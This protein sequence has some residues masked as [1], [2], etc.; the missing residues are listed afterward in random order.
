ME[1]LIRIVS[2]SGIDPAFLQIEV[3]ESTVME[4]VDEAVKTLQRIKVLGMKVA[5][6][7][8]G[9]GYSSL[10]HLSTLP[11]DRLK[12]D[13]SFIR[14]IGHDRTSRAITKAIIVLGHTLKLEVV[15]EGIESEDVLDYLRKQGCDQA[16]G[17]LFSRPLSADEFS[18]WY[19]MR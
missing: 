2:D 9:T 14:R 7:D 18:K 19:R 15:G 13:Q 17:F 3:T 12:V 11:L 5:L 8:F 10:S 16:Q 6:D 4:N 1:R